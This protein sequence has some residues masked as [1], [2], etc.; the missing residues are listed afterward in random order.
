MPEGTSSTQVSNTQGWHMVGCRPR[1]SMH[2]TERA[3]PVAQ[4]SGD[5]CA[6]GGPCMATQSSGVALVPDLPDTGEA[7]G[8]QV[9]RERPLDP[10]HDHQGRIRGRVA[11][12][13]HPRRPEWPR[14]PCG[15]VYVHQLR[16]R[17]PLQQLRVVLV[18]QS[19]RSLYL[20][21][22]CMGLLGQRSDY[23][24][25][26]QSHWSGKRVRDTGVADGRGAAACGK[27]VRG[28][29]ST[30]CADAEQACYPC[31]HLKQVRVRACLRFAS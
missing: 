28:E 11:G 31:T 23:T 24:C 18:L 22:Q 14:V 7:A 2:G 10:R 20:G 6:Q 16:C 8:G 5:I 3:S 26:Q 29:G 19:A 17:V 27:W 9:E 1:T 15:H 25:A 4:P 21:R 12:D 30:T 13:V